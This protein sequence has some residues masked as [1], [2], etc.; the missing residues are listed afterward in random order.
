MG[1]HQPVP[2]PRHVSKSNIVPVQVTSHLKHSKIQ[3]DVVR[4]FNS[5]EDTCSTL[6]GV[7]EDSD[8]LRDVCK[9]AVNPRSNK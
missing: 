4:M 8:F 5:I 7:L 6:A 3:E 9:Q 1:Q 2:D